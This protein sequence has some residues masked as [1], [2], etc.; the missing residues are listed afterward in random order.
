[1]KCLSMLSVAYIT[2]IKLG[3]KKRGTKT[4]MYIN[5]GIQRGYWN[6]KNTLDLQRT[7][8]RFLSTKKQ[9]VKS[10]TVSRLVVS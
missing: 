2:G 1:M 4:E 8:E 7:D 3:H 6:F 10:E 9:E 5:L